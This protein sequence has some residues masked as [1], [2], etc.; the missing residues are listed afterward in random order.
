M[1]RLRRGA[2][3][4]LVVGSGSLAWGLYL[5]A[6]AVAARALLD[7]AW[8]R[9]LETGEVQRPWAWAE[10]WPVARLIAPSQEIDSVVL[11]GAEGASLAFAPGHVDGTAAPGRA[12]NTALAG[13][14]DTTFAFLEKLK[15]G[16]E[17][18]LETPEGTTARYRMTDG[19]IVH[20][21]RR[22]ILDPT[23]GDIL[24]LITCYPFDAWRPGGSLRYVVRAE[25]ETER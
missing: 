14:R 12:G 1:S 7:R 24:T 13:H 18:L 10:T 15:P 16:D 20:E 3:V 19:F 11:A 8:D 6:K 17:L 2:L 4:L 9:T 25:R 21:D 22:E 23:P 5:P